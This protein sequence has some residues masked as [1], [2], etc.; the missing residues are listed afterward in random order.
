[1]GVVRTETS[2]E[3]MDSKFGYEKPT[4]YAIIPAN[5]RYDENLNANEKLMYG[6]LTCLSNKLGYCYA[7]NSY[8]ANLYKVTPQAVSKWI[9]HLES[10]GYIKCQYEYNG[11]EIKQRRITICTQV[12][13]IDVVSTEDNRGIN[14]ELNG[15]QS[16]IKDNI[17]SINNT[18]NNNIY[19]TEEKPK[20]TRKPFIT[21]YEQIL[22][23]CIKNS[24]KGMNNTE[25]EMA[26]W[27]CKVALNEDGTVC[28][29]GNSIKS[30]IGLVSILRSIDTNGKS[31]SKNKSS[32][33][34]VSTIN[35]GCF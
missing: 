10:I 20:R 9:K 24:F 32:S 4:Y 8:F 12:S 19:S 5:V 1:M 18:S 15:Y 31:F 25:G 29:K 2:K 3:I 28:Y 34:P 16:T 13:T 27:F 23:I 33:K 17:T 30:Y 22:N 35:E 14:L 11:L 21:T 26:E 6:E 7:S